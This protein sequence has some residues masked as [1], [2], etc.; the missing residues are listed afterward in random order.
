MGLILIK[1]NLT[2]SQSITNL[3]VYL[4][5]INLSIVNYNTNINPKVNKKKKISR[6]HWFINFVLKLIAVT[7]HT[8]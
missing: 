6:L 3:Q 7:E 5:L 4:R 2:Q 1:T 8:T